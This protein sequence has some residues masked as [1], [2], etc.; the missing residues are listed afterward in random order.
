MTDERLYWLKTM[1]K[2][3]DP[4]LLALDKEQLKLQMPVEQQTNGSREAY[5]H[6]EAFARLVNGMAP[7]L[8]SHA[9]NESEE[10]LRKEYVRRVRKCMDHATNPESRDYMNF[11]SGDQPIVD[12]AFLAQAILRAPHTLWYGLEANVKQNVIRALKATRSRKPYFSNWLLFSAIIET[13]LYKLG[14]EDWDP[15]RIDYA[16][17]QFE[18]WYVGD[19]LY[20][21]GK[22]FHADYY[23][24][25]VIHPMLLDIVETISH[26]YSDWSD[27]L[28][29]IRKRAIQ[30]A[31][32]QER[33]ISPEGTFPPIG[34]SLAY[35]FGAL[36]HLA[37]QV[38]RQELP[39]E[40][41]KG[42]VRAALTA[43]I[44]RTLSA[45][46]VFDKSG[47]LKIG[48]TGHQRDI[49]EGYISTG[50]LYLCAFIFLPLG[51]KESDPFWQENE[52]TWTSKKAWSSDNFP[53]FKSLN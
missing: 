18:Q 8:E 20:S 11:S 53:L 50:S 15:M 26:K 33:L 27:K 2:I 19:G 24:S 4:L 6:L 17:N 7:W 31:R 23:N 9:E 3:A 45:K 37:N 1:T 34:R 40:L 30:Y 38:L 46:N 25:Y 52:Q 41:T 21:D 39:P 14:E 36:H 5:S 10:K 16:V 43:V 35:R 47:W 28:E 51:L 22:S 44:K 42:Q 32:I 13:A 29:N 48:F 49:G 12:T